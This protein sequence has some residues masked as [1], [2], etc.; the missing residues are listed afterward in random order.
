MKTT[1]TKIVAMT[2]LTLM[3]G[4]SAYAGP[5]KMEAGTYHL[6]PAYTKIGFEV[7]HLIV[8][9]VEGHF[10]AFQGEIQFADKLGDSKVQT[11]IQ[12][13]SI[14]TSNQDRDKHLKGSDFFDIEKFPTMTFVSKKITG[15]PNSFKMTGDL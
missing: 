9:S 12:V 2:G 6:D 5:K 1:F 11:T 14:D 4:A 8:S 15:T 7:S 3:L 13:A 10:N